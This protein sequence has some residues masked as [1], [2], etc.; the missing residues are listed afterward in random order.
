MN[1]AELVAARV[2]RPVTHLIDRDGV[3]RATLLD[4]QDYATLER[5]V[6]PLL[7]PRG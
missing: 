7:K 3:L 5:K 2:A 6:A 4:R 1:L